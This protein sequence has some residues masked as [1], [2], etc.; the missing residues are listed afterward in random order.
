MS[1]TSALLSFCVS[2]LRLSEAKPGLFSKRPWSHPP[3]I[4]AAGQ[5]AYFVPPWKVA[6]SLAFSFRKLCLSASSS[7]LTE[8]SSEK[9]PHLFFKNTA[10]PSP[11]A[12][13][14]LGHQ[15]AG[16]H[17]LKLSLLLLTKLL[18]FNRGMA[19]MAKKCGLP[20]AKTP[21]ALWPCGRWPTASKSLVALNTTT[22]IDRL[23]SMQVLAP[24][25]CL[26]LHPTLPGNPAGAKPVPQ[27]RAR[28]FALPRRAPVPERAL[29]D[30]TVDKPMPSSSHPVH[31]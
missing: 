5:S 17:Q 25:D 2:F 24:W 18:E 20:R 7:F 26:A 9:Q 28:D 14:V 3:H 15:L 13:K 19:G 22:T 29:W 8:A 23:T 12:R 16:P 11:S 31:T 30:P 4:H 10:S 6:T 21:L 27:I 1:S